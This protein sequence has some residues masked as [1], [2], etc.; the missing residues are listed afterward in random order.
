[1]AEEPLKVGAHEVDLVRPASYAARYDVL[2]CANLHRACAAAL[3]LCWGRLHRRMRSEGIP[4][5]GDAMAY[6]GQAID[7]LSADG[8]PIQQIVIAGAKALDLCA[9]GLPDLAAAQEAVGNS[10]PPQPAG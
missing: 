3:A 10:E 6:G 8:V 4:Y 7:L 9:E 5:R 1:M 2:R